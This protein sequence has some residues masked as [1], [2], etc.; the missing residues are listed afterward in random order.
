M[1][2]KKKV[3]V[4]K[5]TSFRSYLT[6]HGACGPALDW[7]GKKSMRTAWQ[8][9][10][11]FDWMI[12][13]LNMLEMDKDVEAQ[14]KASILVCIQAYAS[15]K[16]RAFLTAAINAKTALKELWRYRATA[17]TEALINMVIHFRLGNMVSTSTLIEEHD[18]GLLCERLRAQVSVRRL[19]RALDR[20]QGLA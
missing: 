2:A 8:T 16:D 3:K 12:W 14:L 13:L 10:E 15:K 9:C 18:H 17:G 1:R 5:G 19:Q 11:R 6:R 4:P 7:L 20:A